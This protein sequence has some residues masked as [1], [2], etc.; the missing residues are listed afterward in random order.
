MTQRKVFS[1]LAELFKKFP[2]IGQRQAERFTHFVAR[3]DIRYIQN[4]ADTMKTLKGNIK[5]CPECF[6]HH[7]S[8][9]TICEICKRGP[10]DIL[11]IVEKDIDARA[12]ITSTEPADHTHYFVIGGLIPISTNNP[13]KVRLT[14]L[15]KIIQK[16]QPKEIVM[17]FSVHPDAEHT[18]QYLTNSIHTQF[19][20]IVITVLG[21]GLS[22]GSELEYSD[23]ET[24]INAMKGRDRI[25]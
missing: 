11:I 9:E 4:L 12:L 20:D 5:Q 8:E 3:A 10:A 15:T 7:E 18:I 13:D 2:G 6:I 14:Q 23:P 24:L 16:K 19:P 25:S 21:R 1:D 17:A 22:S